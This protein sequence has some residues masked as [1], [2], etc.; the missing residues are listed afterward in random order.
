MMENH[1]SIMIKDE[2]TEFEEAEFTVKISQGG[3]GQSLKVVKE[4][5]E[6]YVET[7]LQHI[8][9]MFKMKQVQREWLKCLLEIIVQRKKLQTLKG[10]YLEL[11]KKQ[12]NM[13]FCQI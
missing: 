7:E 4:E 12:K 3:E 8:D 10:K 1:N 5:E 2:D 9:D 11:W 6:G 13:L